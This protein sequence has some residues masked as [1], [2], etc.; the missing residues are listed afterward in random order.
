MIDIRTIIKKG[1]LRGKIMYGLSFLPDAWYISLF[2]FAVNGKFPNLK[3]PVGY[4]EK[5]QWLKLHDKHP[6]YSILVDKLRVRGV[7]K[8]KLGEGYMFPLLG[9]WE[10]FDDIDFSALPNEFVLKCN[11]DSGSVKII[12]DKSSLTENDL[13]E[14]KKFYDRRISHNFFY[15]GREYPYKDVK[16]CIIAEQLMHN[17]DDE[18]GGIKD[19]KFLCFNGKPEFV[20][21]ISGRQTEKHEDYF[22]MDYNWTEIYNGST[23]SAVCPPKPVC[24]DEMKRIATELCQGF[25]QVRIDLF[26]INGKVYFGEYTIFSGGG[27]E[28]F[29]PEKWEKQFGDWIIL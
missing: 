11:H 10:R 9:N 27:F 14:L 5:L 2:Y 18:L 12:K 24:F 17:K 28:L 22:D 13:Q 15:A 8:E 1:N 26:E 3:N 21:S 6:E 19:Y 20:I 23:P 7:I 25:K 29:K 16:P 4:N